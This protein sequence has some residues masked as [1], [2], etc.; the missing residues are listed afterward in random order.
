LHPIRERKRGFNQSVY[1]AEELQNELNIPIDP[2]VL[3]RVRRT[4]AQTGLNREQRKNNMR[5][6][7]RINPRADLEKK[8][9]I[10]VDDVTTSGA[11]ASE[12]ARILKEGGAREI[13][14]AVLAIAGH[15]IQ[16]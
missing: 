15:D 2:H 14:L 5:G 13:Q 8:R 12:A 4:K 6:A 3:I 10:L 11:T 1:I 16:E 7:F 9:I